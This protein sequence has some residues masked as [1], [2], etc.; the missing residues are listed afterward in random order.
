MS[1]YFLKEVH[2]RKLFLPN[3]APAPFEAVDATYGLLSTSDPYVIAELEKAIRNHIGGVIK[4]TETEFNEWQA[5]K[6]SPTSPFNTSPSGERESL[7][8]M[9]QSQLRNLRERGAAAVVGVDSAGNVQPSLNPTISSPGQA[10][11]Q[12]QTQKVEPLTVPTAFSIPRVGVAAKAT[13]KAAPA[14]VQNKP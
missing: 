13:R 5:K 3:G 12:A 9:S 4:L 8:A 7:G 10:H 2:E 11:Q 6:K 1:E 14:P